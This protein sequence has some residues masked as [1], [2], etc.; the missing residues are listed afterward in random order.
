MT[1][2]NPP[3]RDKDKTVLHHIKEGRD[4]IQKITEAT[5]LENHEVNYCF[6]KLEKLGLI[7]VEKPDGMVERVVDGQ[8]RVFEAP[9]RAELAEEGDQYLKD[10]EGG[11]VEAYDEMSSSDLIKRFRELEERVDQL[12]N[13]IEAFRRQILGKLEEK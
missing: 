5:T 7:E 9:K 13:S 8:K 4:D 10:I 12:E 1:S 3:L 2:G 11:T 6:Q